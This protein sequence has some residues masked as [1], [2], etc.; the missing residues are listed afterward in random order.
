MFDSWP[1]C[2]QNRIAYIKNNRI[3]LVWWT[4]QFISLHSGS[5]A[6]VGE[7]L[8]YITLFGDPN[9]PLHL[10]AWEHGSFHEG[11]YVIW[12]KCNS[13]QYV[14]L[15]KLMITESFLRAFGLSIELT[16]SSPF[17]QYKEPS[18]MYEHPSQVFKYF[19]TKK[20]GNTCLGKKS[21]RFPEKNN[22]AIVPT[23]FFLKMMPMPPPRLQHFPLSMWMPTTPGAP[24]W[25]RHRSARQPLWK[26][27]RPPDSSAR[28]LPGSRHQLFSPAHCFNEFFFIW[29]GRVPF[30]L[31][32][33]TVAFSITRDWKPDTGDWVRP[34]RLMEVVAQQPFSSQ[35]LFMPPKYCTPPPPGIGQEGPGRGPCAPR[36]LTW[37]LTLPFNFVPGR[38]P[39][40]F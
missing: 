22:Q 9:I 10:T 4:P 3:P 16:P 28:C 11:S 12:L 25:Q 40:G 23:V 34:T 18:Y 38:T 20:Y 29:R 36:H 31:V 24:S 2:S 19:V 15:L 14:F 6:W 21:T 13:I 37:V 27:P 33:Q 8:Q 35:Q 26:S 5:Q 30:A 32:F 17:I 7:L 1:F 39:S